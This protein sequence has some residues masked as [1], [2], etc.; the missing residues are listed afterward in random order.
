[1]LP[2][3]ISANDRRKVLEWLASYRSEIRQRHPYWLMSFSAADREYLLDIVPAREPREA[4]AKAIPFS[5][6][7]QRIEASYA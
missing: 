4:V 2:R 3:R 1:M 7:R 5:L 6:G